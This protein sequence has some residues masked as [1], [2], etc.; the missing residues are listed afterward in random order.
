MQNATPTPQTSS[1]RLVAKQTSALVALFPV[2][3]S[4]LA[5]FTPVDSGA[6]HNF[7]AASSLTKL[8][9]FPSFVSIVPCQLQVTLAAGGVVQ[10]AQLTTLALELVD[11]QGVIVPGMPALEFYVLDMLPA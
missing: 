11:D 5:V 10:A 1:L 2:K 3:F 4:D 6:I 7:F 8:C 9:D